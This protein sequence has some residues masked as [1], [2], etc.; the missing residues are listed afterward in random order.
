MAFPKK[1]SELPV[2]G[3]L[4]NADLLAIVSGGVTSQT[5]LGEISAAISGHS[6]P[7]FTGNTTFE[8]DVIISGDTKLGGDLDLCPGGTIYC[9]SFSGCSPITFY[10]A[11]NIVGGISIDPSNPDTI[12]KIPEYICTNCTDGSVFYTTQNL[13]QYVDKTVKFE[14]TGEICW[15]ITKQGGLMVTESWDTEPDGCDQCGA[16]PAGDNHKYTACGG[17]E[18]E[19][20]KFI[21]DP[22]NPLID[23]G[24]FNF[25]CCWYYIDELTSESI[26]EFSPTA[27]KIFPTDLD[28]EEAL[29]HFTTFEITPCE[30]TEGVT[31]YVNCFDGIRPNMVVK[32]EEDDV[33][34]WQVIK[35]SS[36]SGPIATYV[37]VVEEGCADIECPS[38]ESELLSFQPGEEDGIVEVYYSS[39][40]E[41]SGF[42]IQ[43]RP[44]FTVIEA[45]GIGGAAGDAEWSVSST[46]DI[47]IGEDNASKVTMFSYTSTTI[48]PTDGENVLLCTLSIMENNEDVTSDNPLSTARWTTMEN[49]IG[50]NGTSNDWVPG[51]ILNVV[52]VVAII[53]DA[54]FNYFGVTEVGALAEE[55][56][57]YAPFLV[58]GD[59]TGALELIVGTVNCFTGSGEPEAVCSIEE[60]VASNYV[61]FADYGD[62]S[63]VPWPT[64]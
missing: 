43:F 37:S 6:I 21:T 36:E 10:S 60:P 44:G 8:G 47:T 28:C 23:I 4:S 29:M 57:D 9:S 18:C 45:T 58:S 16:E 3:S 17:Q 13:Q 63:A 33:G 34:C 19:Y 59:Q 64:E 51:G 14:H 42:N 2:S 30:G 52:D 25:N 32:I 5:T 53:N 7:Q 48:P 15:S 54:A 26:T 11:V 22:A 31:M 40:V 24:L 27:D 12:I 55:N 41:I 39:Q 20:E 50:M 49:N 61:T 62:G 56:A 46:P 38:V 1:I 35:P